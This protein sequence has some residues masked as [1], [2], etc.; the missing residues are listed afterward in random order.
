MTIRGSGKS[1]RQI[2]QQFFKYVFVGVCSNAALYVVY[3][4]LT[5]SLLSPKV[6]MTITYMLGIGLTFIFNR[7]W[8]FEH[9]G[10][11]NPALVRY[12]TAYLSGY[13]LNLL[14]LSF[15]VDQLQCPHQIVQA[16]MV[17]FLAMYLF[18]LQRT[19]VFKKHPDLNE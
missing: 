3:L 13:L 2:R 10:P 15:F 8:T 1:L 9:R 16:C 19:W 6:G 14:A 12:V 7:S 11:G 17:I 4:L 18:T 5:M